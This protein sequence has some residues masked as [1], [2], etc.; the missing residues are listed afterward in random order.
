MYGCASRYWYERGAVEYKYW[1]NTNN[2]Q[3]ADA[4]RQGVHQLVVICTHQRGRKDVRE[5]VESYAG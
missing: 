4:V 2:K 1:L 5:L 3:A